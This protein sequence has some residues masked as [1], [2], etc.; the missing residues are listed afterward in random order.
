[1]EII[2]RLIYYGC[3]FVSVILA[4]YVDFTPFVIVDIFDIQ[5]ESKIR[6]H[7]ESLL[8][9]DM[10]RKMAEEKRAEI[11]NNTI[12]ISVNVKWIEI[13][14]SLKAFILCQYFSLRIY[15]Q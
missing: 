11:E 6:R 4:F 5:K 10:R 1:M 14:N 3:C 2:R 15:R 7:A 13:Y 8:G 9:E 12:T